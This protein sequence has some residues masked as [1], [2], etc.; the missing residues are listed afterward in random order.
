M[1]VRLHILCSLI[2]VLLLASCQL[3]PLEE[4]SGLINVEVV[5]E[6]AGVQNVTDCIYN[7][8]L[9]APVI[10]SDMMRCMFYNPETDRLVAQSFLSDK[11]I[12]EQGREVFTGR[13]NLEPGTYNILCYNFD[14]PYTLIWDESEYSKITAYSSEIPMSVKSRF[15][16]LFSK[17]PEEDDVPIY[18]MP[19]HLVVSRDPG[20]VIKHHADVLTIHTEAST[21]IDTYYI[22]IG[23]KN[24]QYAS[25]IS[26]VLGGLSRENQIS[27]DIRETEHPSAIFFDLSIGKDERRSG[28]NKDV[29]CGLFN[30]FGKIDT[31]SSG[32]NVTFNVIST[33]GEIIEKT[34]NLDKVFETEDATKRHWLIIDDEIVIPDPGP[35]PGP[36]SSGFN[37]K[38]KDWNKEEDSITF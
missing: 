28:D 30:T 14:T 2:T 32:L 5:I 25:G 31:A 4:P 7:P 9:E 6:T 34:F 22:Q 27:G 37:P 20:Y 17:A 38:I 33:S 12:D 18:Y 16:A 8:D 19:D 21:I 35:D 1:S 15:S 3:R 36:P 23:V 13:M 11:H 26:A 24:A 10:S 29:I